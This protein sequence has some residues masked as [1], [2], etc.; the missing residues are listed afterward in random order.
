MITATYSYGALVFSPETRAMRLS[1]FDGTDMIASIVGAL[2]APIIKVNFGLYA[3]YGVKLGV[4]FL[5]LIYG[6]FVTL[7]HARLIKKHTQ[8]VSFILLCRNPRIKRRGI[9]VFL[10]PAAKWKV[11]P[12]NLQ[13]C[14]FCNMHVLLHIP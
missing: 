10:L 6:L 7:H 2:L 14:G 5:S 12:Q 1:I 3:C 11:D 13:R 4:S 9:L 8:K